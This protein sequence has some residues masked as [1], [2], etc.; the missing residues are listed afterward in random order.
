LT[1][2]NPDF[3]CEVRAEGH[4]FHVDLWGELDLAGSPE[5]REALVEASGRPGADVTVDAV[6]LTFLDSTGISV[7]VSACK[8]IRAEGGTFRLR[9]VSGV[10]RRVLEVSGLIEYFGVDS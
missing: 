4:A 1:N 10:V 9:N 3:G 8:R 5:L 6:R 7:L 2:E